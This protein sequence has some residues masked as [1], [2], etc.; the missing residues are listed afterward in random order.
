LPD[1]CTR[2]DGKTRAGGDWLPT[3]KL[4]DSEASTALQPG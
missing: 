3:Y 2:S 4:R 1:E